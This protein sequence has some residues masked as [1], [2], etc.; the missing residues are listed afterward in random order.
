MVGTPQVLGIYDMKGYKPRSK[1]N[2]IVQKASY[3]YFSLTLASYLLC[4]LSLTPIPQL[5][6]LKGTHDRGLAYNHMTRD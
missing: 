5:V 3:T 2:T 1:P 6:H 4:E